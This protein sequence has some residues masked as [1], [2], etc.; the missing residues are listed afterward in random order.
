[1]K[2]YMRGEHHAEGH[3]VA[4]VNPREIQGLF[5]MIGFKGVYDNKTG[6]YFEEYSWQ[7]CYGESGAYAEII[8]SQT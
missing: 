2:V 1:M 3:E 7:I 6:E 4:D 5:N 8:L